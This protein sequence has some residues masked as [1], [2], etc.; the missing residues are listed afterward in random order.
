MKTF[1]AAGKDFNSA[2]SVNESIENG[3]FYEQQ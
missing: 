2:I 1:I 3:G